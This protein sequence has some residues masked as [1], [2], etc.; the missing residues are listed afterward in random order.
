VVDRIR[1]MR[2]PS[3]SYRD[4]ILRFAPPPV[5]RRWPEVAANDD[6]RSD[7]EAQRMAREW[8]RLGAP[9]RAALMRAGRTCGSREGLLLG[10]RSPLALLKKLGVALA[11]SVQS[12]FDP[13]HGLDAE[14]DLFPF[15]RAKPLNQLV[16][17][18]ATAELVSEVAQ[19]TCD[20][21]IR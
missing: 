17:A 20:L 6:V 16:G 18:L 8:K 4:V 1:A 19:V 14:A 9:G 21:R 10:L 13:H 7:R 2:R 12:R 5:R 11:Q 15:V 3:Y